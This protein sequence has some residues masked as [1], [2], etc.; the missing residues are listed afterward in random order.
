MQ[1]PPPVPNVMLVNASPRGLD[2]Q[3]GQRL[4]AVV[5]R[6]VPAGQP[7]PVRIG[8]Q[9]LQL[10]LPASLPQGAR[11]S[12]Q[13]MQAGSQPVLRL[14]ST[15]PGLPVSGLQT[16][17]PPGLAA[18]NPGL[19]NPGLQALPPRT[20]GLANAGQGRPNALVA[21]A[22]P[23]LHPAAV[24]P[25]ALS[26]L[27]PAQGSQAPLLATLWALKTHAA[28][29]AAL[30]SAVRTAV[31]HLFQRLASTSQ[32]GHA[33]GL[34]QAVQMSGLFHETNVA[35]WSAAQASTA[36][37]PADLKSLLLSLATR[38]RALPGGSAGGF[39]PAMGLLRETPPPRTGSSPV[40]QGRLTAEVQ[41]LSPQALLG[42]LR[43]AT[44][45]AVARLALHQW[46]AAESAETG[47]SRWLLE[48]PLKAQNGVDLV[49][50]LLEREPDRGPS[51][52]DAV[53]RIALALDLPGLGP[54]HVR[55]AVAGDRVDARLWAEEK[56]TVH[57]V[58]QELPR[59]RTALEEHRLRVRDLGCN[60]GAPPEDPPTGPSRPVLDDQA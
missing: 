38:L 3:P 34:R 44:E 36:R 25:A 53:W 43:L 59:L 2:W 37:P 35:A 10:Q 1:I 13:V 23:S 4:E 17:G 16:P 48:L 51:E 47:A 20:P 55:L 30:P 57:R 28:P 42:G 15:V 5:V 58:R 56:T 60:P 22:L 31:D 21:T 39:L 32:A 41:G 45:Q 6:A 12:L 40:A 19:P 26:H 50:L 14:L 8:E 9:Q 11:I 54:V 27:L 7:T 18:Q 52:A 29:M 49:H 46:G 24:A 33:Q